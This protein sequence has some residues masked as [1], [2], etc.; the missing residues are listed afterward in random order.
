MQ[1]RGVGGRRPYGRVCRARAHLTVREVCSAL[2]CM[3]WSGGSH[4]DGPVSCAL[5]LRLNEV[6]SSQVPDGGRGTFHRF[7]GAFFRIGVEVPSTASKVPFSRMGVEVP[8]T[9]SEVPFFGWGR[10]NFHRFRGAFFSDGRGIFH[11]FRGA[12]FSDGGSSSTALEWFFLN[13][14]MT[15]YGGKS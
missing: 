6:K 1:G 14:V 15:Y 4:A 13:G 2:P 11:R 12:F 7:R 8:S 9:A 10:G 5:A 3:L